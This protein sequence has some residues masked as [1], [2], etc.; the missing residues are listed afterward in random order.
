[1]SFIHKLNTLR[2]VPS[3]DNCCDR[4]ES[5]RLQEFCETLHEILLPGSSHLSPYGSGGDRACFDC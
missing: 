4:P 3:T 5:L 2:K 1:M